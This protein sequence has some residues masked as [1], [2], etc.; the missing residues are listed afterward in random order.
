VIEILPGT[1]LYVKFLLDL[2]LI[3]R[4]NGM[5]VLSCLNNKFRCY[6]YTHRISNFIRLGTKKGISADFNDQNILDNSNRRLNSSGMM[7]K[8][9][10]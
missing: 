6:I 9:H 3:D 4:R 10:V 7:I 2:L 5:K 1:V 8:V